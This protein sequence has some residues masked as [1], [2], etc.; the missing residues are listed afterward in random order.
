MTTLPPA[1]TDRLRRIRRFSL[2]A[3]AL[4]LLGTGLLAAFGVR[5]ALEG[6]LAAWLF[7]LGLSHGG[8]VLL[9]LSHVVTGEWALLAQR[10]LA[11][12]ARTTAWLAPLF[13]PLIVGMRW[14][15]PW[16]DPVQIAQHEVLRHQHAYLNPLFF[17][18]RAVVYFAVW[19][20]G[21]YGLTHLSL[22]QDATG[23]EA[24]TARLRRLA[25]V[26]LIAHIVALLF[27]STDWI[28]SLE[29]GWT[30]TTLG[31]LVLGSQTLAAAACAALGLLWLRK[32][33]PLAR[34][35][36][37]KHLH[38]WGTVLFALVALWAYLAFMQFLIIW[39]GDLPEEVTWYVHRSTGGWRW[40]AALLAVFHFAAPFA[41]LLSRRTKR[42][43]RLLAGV[44]GGL[45]V[46]HAVYVL[47]LVV[48]SFPPVGPRT[49]LAWAAAFVGVGGVWGAGF[50]WNLGRFGLLPR[51]DP[52]L[53]GVTARR[54][55]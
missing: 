49:L 21:A 37:T 32:Y 52:R 47:W 9:S 55:S 30:T 42:T 11:A 23:D 53:A 3:A 34:V 7:W 40:V 25:V 24:F 43:P 28:V 10:F 14:V 27:A 16:L 22:R 38:D 44:A 2:V 48:P 5:E 4:G 35:V 12:M 26:V 51:H 15:F 31:W 50:T 45:L 36:R 29:P 17:T 1:L 46:V 8:L 54:E 18:A 33:E 39:S 19:I 13:L 20:G 6:F 41:L